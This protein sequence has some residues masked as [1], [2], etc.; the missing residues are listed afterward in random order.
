M[1]LVNAKSSELTK[2]CLR[3]GFA[4]ILKIMVSFE[5]QL[6]SYFKIKLDKF[7]QKRSFLSKSKIKEGLKFERYFFDLQ[8]TGQFWSF[9]IL[10]EWK[11]KKKETKCRQKRMTKV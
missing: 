2:S 3:K 11:R 7:V 6:L 5:T 4:F 9:L 8:W 1:S 10:M